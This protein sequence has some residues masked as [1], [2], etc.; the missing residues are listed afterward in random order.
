MCE[1]ANRLISFDFDLVNP[2]HV[3][4][5]EHRYVLVVFL[6]LEIRRAEVSSEEDQ[7]HLIDDTALLL[8]FHRVLA[9][10][11]RHCSPFLLGHV[12]RIVILEYCG[13]MA[14]IDDDFVAISD[15]VVKRSAIGKC[16]FCFGAVELSVNLGQ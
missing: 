12:E 1:T 13:V 4:D 2:L 11:V 6:V 8:F 9:R 3:F 14:S 10:N 7:Q 16:F 15:H 5:V